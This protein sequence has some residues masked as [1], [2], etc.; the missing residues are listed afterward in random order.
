MTRQKD[1][2][3]PQKDQ[4]QVKIDCFLYLFFP[5]M[6]APQAVKYILYECRNL[7]EMR[8]NAFLAIPKNENQKLLGCL[9]DMT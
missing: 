9:D 7:A 6:Y 2:K 3:N 4:T 8:E 1:K 5:Q